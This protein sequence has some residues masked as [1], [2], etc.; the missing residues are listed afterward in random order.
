MSTFLELCQDAARESGTVTGTLP[1]T[2]ESQTGRLAKIVSWTAEAWLQIQNSRN[3]WFF[4]RKEFP[5]TAKTSANT[6]RYLPASWNID[7]FAAWLHEEDSITIYLESEGV[8]DEDSIRQISWQDYRYRYERGAQTANRPLHY[9]ISPANEF[10][11]GPAP[12]GVYVLRGE[13]RRTAQILAANADVPLCDPRFHKVIPWKAVLLL[14]AH[15]EAPPDRLATANFEYMNYM[16]AL[17]RD[18]LPRIG[19]AAEPLA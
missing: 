7:D 18:Q 4:H 15:D 1:S 12:D 16:Q 13:Y 8:A 10:C 14:I 2:V 3:A 5:A 6:K 11:I 19:L 17:E 9:A